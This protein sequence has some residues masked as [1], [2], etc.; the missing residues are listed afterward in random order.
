MIETITLDTR[1]D[2]TG[3]DNAHISPLRRGERNNFQLTVVVLRDSKPYDLTGMTA[4]LVWKAADGKLVGPVPMEVTDATEGIVSC[5]LPAAC[6]SAV[7]MARAYVELRRGAEMVDTTD[8]MS[9]KVLDCIDADSEQAEEYKP[10][11]AEVQ[12]A[13]ADAK[14][15][16]TEASDAASH[17]PRIGSAGTWEVWDIV[18]ARYVDTG[19][20]AQG[21]KGDPGSDATATDVRI[22]GTSITADGVAD[23][24]A[25]VQGSGTYGVV[26]MGWY[27][28][29]L[30]I[31]GNGEISIVDAN[32]S[33]IDSRASGSYPITT[34]W[35]DYVVKAAMCDGKGAAWTAAEQAA[36]RKRM[37]IDAAID[38]AIKAAIQ[39]E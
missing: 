5:I 13:V 29:G 10:L 8:E 2:Y 6:Y 20:A 19:V 36:A 31:N 21:E 32:N 17:Q 27:S 25:A 15:A 26:K 39:K 12:N 28:S 7:G 22:N 14:R 38:A 18:S 3:G 4:H 23:I 16:T 34:N 35:F 30:R 9:I 1:K 33:A 24:P 37:G 11:I